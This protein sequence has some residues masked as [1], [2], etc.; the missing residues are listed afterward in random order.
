MPEKFEKKKFVFNSR[1]LK[2]PD[3]YTQLALNCQKGWHRPALLSTVGVVYQISLPLPCC[4]KDCH[5]K[6][7]RNTVADEPPLTLIPLQKYRNGNG[8]RIV[9]QMGGV[10]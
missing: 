8:S 6:F 5:F 9:I 1:P 4:H 2:D 3:F 7:L 10:S